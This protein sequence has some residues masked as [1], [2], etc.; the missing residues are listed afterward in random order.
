MTSIVVVVWIMLCCA[1][2]MEV[3]LRLRRYRRGASDTV[4]TSAQG[5]RKWLG[6]PAAIWL[7]IIVLGLGLVTGTMEVQAFVLS[8]SLIN[9]LP[10]LPI[11]LMLIGG[12]L[13]LWSQRI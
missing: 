6:L 4:S 8:P 5:S 12:S 10:A 2:L 9:A 11:P 13:I 7:G 3:G 1:T